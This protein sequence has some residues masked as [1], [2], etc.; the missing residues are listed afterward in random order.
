MQC[1]RIVW[2]IKSISFMLRGWFCYHQVLQVHIDNSTTG[3]ET[4][5]RLCVYGGPRRQAV[6]RF[7]I[8]YT[9]ASEMGHGEWKCWLVGTEIVA[10]DCGF[11]WNLNELGAIQELWYSTFIDFILRHIGWQSWIPNECVEGVDIYY[12]QGWQRWFGVVTCDNRNKRLES[13]LEL[14]IIV[15]KYYV[16]VKL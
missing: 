13:T 9:S 11:M 4:V 10:I 1:T 8:Y 2:N 7:C 14:E 12:F 15:E 6:N 5:V 3:T 16:E